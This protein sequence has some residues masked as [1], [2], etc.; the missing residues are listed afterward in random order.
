[1]LKIVPGLLA[2]VLLTGCASPVA[3][4]AQADPNV[5]NPFRAEFGADL[6]A[7]V[8]HLCAREAGRPS[9]A[10]CATWLEASAALVGRMYAVDHEAMGPFNKRMGAAAAFYAQQKC[11]TPPVDPDCEDLV[12]E[13]GR[14][15]REIEARHLR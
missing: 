10:A 9:A 7:Q 14:V 15:L 1:M 2:L 3:G 11:A 12:A 4:Q 6:A 8:G 13:V 5:P